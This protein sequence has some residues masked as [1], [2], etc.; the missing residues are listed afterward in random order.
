MFKSTA[1]SFVIISK[2]Y[3][4]CWETNAYTTHAYYKGQLDGIGDG[5]LGNGS[6]YTITAST[7]S[8][9]FEAVI[10]AYTTLIL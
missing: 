6:F 2:F 4:L 1:P 3:F 8:N 10:S 5:S 7:S 9:F